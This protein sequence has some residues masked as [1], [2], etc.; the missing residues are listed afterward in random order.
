MA[1]WRGGMPWRSRRG[2]EGFHWIEPNQHTMAIALNRT[3]PLDFSAQIRNQAAKSGF[4]PDPPLPA[5]LRASPKVNYPA[6]N[7]YQKYAM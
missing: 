4:G 1:T 6:S 2:Y 5:L 3:G 7:L